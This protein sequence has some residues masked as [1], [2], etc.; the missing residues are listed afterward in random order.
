MGKKARDVFEDSM[1]E[2]KARGLR[3]QGQRSS[4]PRPQN[5]VLKVSSRSRPGFKDL[6]PWAF[7]RTM[8]RR[9]RLC[10]VV[11]LSITLKFNALL[12]PLV[13]VYEV[14]YL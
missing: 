11:C 3:G 12:P 1:V 8:L 7:Y 13:L 5:F 10:H 9:E 14:L 2:A 4:R 6:D